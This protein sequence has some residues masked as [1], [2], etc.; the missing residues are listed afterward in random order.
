MNSCV[1]L[2]NH[3]AFFFKSSNFI[4]HR[5]FNFLVRVL[6]L[7]K[8]HRLKRKE[9]DIDDWQRKKIA[10]AKQKMRNA[11]VCSVTAVLFEMGIR[12]SF[13]TSRPPLY[14]D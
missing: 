13:L 10:K 14:L 11:E 12:S 6:M 8:P 1:I 9:A 3:Y 7:L 4:T 2:S 5:S